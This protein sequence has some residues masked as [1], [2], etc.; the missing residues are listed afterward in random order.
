MFV[1]PKCFAMDVLRW[2]YWSHRLFYLRQRNKGVTPI[3]SESMLYARTCIF[4]AMR[5]AY[6]RTLK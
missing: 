2:F 6:R 1:F 3:S 4:A 5:S